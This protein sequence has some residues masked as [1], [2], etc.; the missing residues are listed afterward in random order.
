MLM[1]GVRLHS[2]DAVAFWW[3][4]HVRALRRPS[5]FILSFKK[6]TSLSGLAKT[7]HDALTSA[8]I[9]SSVKRPAAHETQLHIFPIDCV[10]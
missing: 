2:Q 8:V 3:E 10:K 7:R 4:F 9:N 1:W 6:S 5:L